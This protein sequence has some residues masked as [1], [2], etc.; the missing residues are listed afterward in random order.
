MGTLDRW[1]SVANKIGW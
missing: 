1:W